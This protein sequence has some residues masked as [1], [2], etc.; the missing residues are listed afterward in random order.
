MN[1]LTRGNS[2]LARYIF[3]WSLTPIKSCL[4]CEDCKSDC[5]AVKS[6]RFYPSVKLAWD[7]NLELARSGDFV[8]HIIDQLKRARTCKVVRIHVAGDFISQEYIDYWAVIVGTFPLLK[9]YAYTKVMDM[10]DFTAINEYENFNLIDSI[11]IDGGVNFGDN[12]RVNELKDL[13]YTVCPATAGYNISC[14][15]GCNYCF[16]NNKVCFKVH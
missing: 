4:N 12:D 15:K 7:R 9:F 1:L 8:G 13:G 11:C 3:N 10:F 5:Y 14:G 16:T 6:Y 2:K